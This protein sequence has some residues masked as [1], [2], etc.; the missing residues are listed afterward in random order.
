MPRYKMIASDLDGTFLNSK[1]EISP[2]NQAAI[3][4]LQERGILFISTSGRAY[5][6]MDV[7]LRENPLLRYYIY[8]DGAVIFDQQTGERDTACM[9]IALSNRVYDIM[10]EY[11]V[12][13]VAHIE[14]YSYLDGKMMEEQ[15]LAHHRISPYYGRILAERNKAVENFEEF[16]RSREEIELIFGFF[17]SDEE[18]EECRKRL[19]ALGGLQVVSSEPGTFEIISDRAGKGNGVLRLAKKLGIAPSEV[20]TAG[21]SSND[22]SMLQIGGLS[23]AVSNAWDEVKEAADRVICSNDEHIVDYILKNICKE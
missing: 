20:I 12:F 5:Y 22:I 3:K 7:A 6:E 19:E 11:Q 4:A 1:M 18:M 2:E 16:F 14:E 8:S 17:H 15:T 23:L 13:I 21:D 9:D 10:S